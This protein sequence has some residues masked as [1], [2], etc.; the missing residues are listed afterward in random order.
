MGGHLMAGL[1]GGLGRAGLCPLENCRKLKNFKENAKKS[2][3][4]ANLQNEISKLI[5]KLS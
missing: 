1:V 4:L 2:N 5:V 3:I